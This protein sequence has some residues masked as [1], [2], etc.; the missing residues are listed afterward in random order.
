MSTLDPTLPAFTP[1]A[2]LP[3][4]EL[5]S[6]ALS[7]VLSR[8]A[9]P[10]TKPRPDQL[11]ATTALLEKGSRV[12]VVQATGWG[13]SA[14]YWSAALALRSRATGPVLVVSPLL[15]LMRDQVNAA[16]KAG[17]KAVTINSSNFDEWGHLLQEISSDHVDVILISPERLANDSFSGALSDILS[18]CALVVIDEAH[19]I[20]DWGFD[21]RPDYQRLATL[22][23]SHPALSI[24]ATTATAN[25]RV[26][27]DVAEQLGSTTL[28]LRGPLSRPSLRLG[29]KPGLDAVQAFA[30]IDARLRTMEGSGIIYVP[31]TELTTKLSAYLGQRGHIV[32]PYSGRLSTQER[33][34]VEDDLRDNRI[35]AA[36]ATSALGMGYDKP[37]LGFVIHLG[38]PSSPV[39]YYQQ[40]GRAGRSLDHAEI[41]LIPQPSDSALW[42]YFATSSIPRPD[43]IDSLRS[44]LSSSPTPLGSTALSDLTGIRPARLDALLKVLLVEN[45]IISFRD[46]AN[47]IV[48][49]LTDRSYEYDYPHWDALRDARLQEASLMRAYA[50]QEGCLM[51][52]LAV[53]LDDPDSSPCGRCSACTESLA[54]DPPLL[55]TDLDAASTFLRARP[56]ELSPRKLFP[57]GLPAPFTGKIPDILRPGFALVAPDAIGF[58]DL[59]T[60]LDS[61]DA[62]PP[63]SLVDA[64]VALGKSLAT[65]A[66]PGCLVVH[67][68]LTHPQLLSGLASA[69]AL[70][71]DIPVY[72]P[73]ASASPPG[74]PSEPSKQVIR[75]VAKTMALSTS[76]IPPAGPAILLSLRRRTGWTM[77]LAALMLNRRALS[78]IYP[79]ALYQEP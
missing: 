26:T 2:L 45:T 77:T 22:I 17:L 44:A 51:Q 76:F 13:K 32:A 55:V 33:A 19:C 34:Q 75:R 47:K 3:D 49:A 61:P 59:T 78:P 25:S 64:F 63:Q 57:S 52:F 12:L 30:W 15:A 42:D 65:T 1:S 31:T 43:H 37:D 10:S 29:V 74:E 4:P 20:S 8:L 53:A 6:Q 40:I 54:F 56:V 21:F 11:V 14:V 68:D 36:V 18:R 70:A 38:S 24:L 58:P 39:A 50:N 28:V 48:Y 79:L 69:L 41:V 5:A 7:F 66:H 67:P 23:T 9:G 71:L 46:D 35:K 60:A 16:T 27:S 73:F 62:P 72:H